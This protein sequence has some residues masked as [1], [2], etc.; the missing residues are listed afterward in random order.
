MIWAF[1]SMRK[2]L[3]RPKK[4]EDVKIELSKEKIIFKSSK[5]KSSLS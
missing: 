1:I 2:E 5:N 3:R 4:L